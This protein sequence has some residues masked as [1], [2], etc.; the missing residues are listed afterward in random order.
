MLTPVKRI[1]S[2]SKPKQL[3]SSTCVGFVYSFDPFS[4]Q[5]IAYCHVFIS[6]RATKIPICFENSSICPIIWRFHE[7]SLI[8]WGGIV[9]SSFGNLFKYSYSLISC[10]ASLVH[11][12]EF[13]IQ[14]VRV[15]VLCVC[16]RVLFKSRTEQSVYIERGREIHI[17]CTVSA[18]S[19]LLFAKSIY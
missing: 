8:Y 5:I 2:H 10:G 15:H 9:W 16:V 1:A 14:Y 3:K 7:H 6:F 17:D 12:I 18:L 13:A 11:R 19:I 4:L